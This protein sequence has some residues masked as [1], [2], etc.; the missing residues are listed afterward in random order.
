MPDLVLSDDVLSG[1]AM[2]RRNIAAELLS[3]VCHLSCSFHMTGN[4]PFD[5]GGS[6]AS[7]YVPSARCQCGMASDIPL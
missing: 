5:V 2:F 1:F 6:V 7:Q 3:C 4:S